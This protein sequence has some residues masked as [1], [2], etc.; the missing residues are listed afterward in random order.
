MYY[1]VFLFINTIKLMFLL[2][3]TPL[4]LRCPSFITTGPA[5]FPSSCSGSV[6]TQDLPQ[7]S[8]ETILILLGFAARNSHRK[9]WR[10]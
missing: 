10:F 8:K 7:R 9:S 1:N 5:K 4:P 3:G 2:N 6:Q